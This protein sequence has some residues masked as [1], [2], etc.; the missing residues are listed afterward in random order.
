MK[1]PPSKQTPS[2]SA[3]NCTWSQCNRVVRSPSH[4]WSEAATTSDTIEE[5]CVDKMH[6]EINILSGNTEKYFEA[7]K[8]IAQSDQQ[9]TTTRKSEK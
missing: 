2:A 9:V 5:K 3:S 8:P 7:N 6:A 1:L 4:Y